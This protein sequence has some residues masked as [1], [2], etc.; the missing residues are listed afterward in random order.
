MLGWRFFTSSV[1]SRRTDISLDLKHI[2]KRLGCEYLS[3]TTAQPKFP[4]SGVIDGHSS[5]RPMANL[6][7]EKNDFKVNVVFLI[8]TTS[9]NTYIS[10][11]VW[12]ALGCSGHVPEAS[13]ISLHGLQDFMVERSPLDSHFA[14]INILGQNYFYFANID[15]FQSVKNET[16]VL[17]HQCDE[18]K[19]RDVV[20]TFA[21]GDTII[22]EKD[23][24]LATQDENE[25]V[26]DNG[27]T[28]L[29][30]VQ[31]LRLLQLLREEMA[32][33]S[34]A[35]CKYF[36]EKKGL[37]TSSN[38]SQLYSGLNNLSTQ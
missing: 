21:Q 33:M 2:S 30:L 14:E 27:D 32:T 7:V 24:Y 35:Y 11:Q 6:I 20:K 38:I 36:I 1:R 9:P 18:N 5:F 12:E 3:P 10:H 37:P 25:E 16:I 28:R 15:F 17:T 13:H 4:V 19:L 34:E 22:T 31:T 26:K 8:D 23:Q 29:T